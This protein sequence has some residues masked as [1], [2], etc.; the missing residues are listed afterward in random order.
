MEG[1]LV[2]KSKV[3]GTDMLPCGS[4]S[5]QETIA[6][7]CEAGVAKVK[8]HWAPFLRS[9]PRMWLFSDNT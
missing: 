7:L 6:R 5:L 1:A 9:A 8:G 3:G 2:V 4:L